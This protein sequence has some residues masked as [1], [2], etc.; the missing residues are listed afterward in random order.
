MEWYQAPLTHQT[1]PQH[2]VSWAGHAQ[3]G[4]LFNVIPPPQGQG[5]GQQGGTSEGGSGEHGGEGGSGG[6][7]PPSQPQHSGSVD[8]HHGMI[9]NVVP[10]HHGFWPNPHGQP[11]HMMW[12]APP[13]QSHPGFM[14]TMVPPY[15]PTY[16]PAAPPMSP[17]TAA[18]QQR[19]SWPAH[20][21]PPATPQSGVMGASSW[22]TPPTG[23]RHSM[24][25]PALGWGSVPVTNAQQSSYSHTTSK[26]A[27]HGMN[28]VG[29]RPFVLCPLW[30]IWMGLNRIA[31]GL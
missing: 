13:P 7:P 22:I 26:G 5:Q 8:Y 11:H 16:W 21:H 15:P 17:R 12:S 3:S 29:S 30:R 19:H 9:F 14:P 25:A 1:P 10:Q 23:Q 4:H 2:G 27:H 18:E 24:P 31:W 20:Q 28:G 6:P